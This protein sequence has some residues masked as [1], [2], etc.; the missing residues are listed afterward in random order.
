MKQGKK[1]LDLKC[2]ASTSIAVFNQH[3]DWAWV[4]KNSE[5]EK[6]DKEWFGLEGT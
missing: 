3:P 4:G 6:K 5:K 1:T 2:N